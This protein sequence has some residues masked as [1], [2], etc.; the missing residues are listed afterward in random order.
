MA[1]RTGTDETTRRP[2]AGRASL[3]LMIAAAWPQ[4]GLAQQAAP[5]ETIT[6]IGN[7]PLLGY[8]ENRNFSEADTKLVYE[9]IYNA[10]ATFPCSNMPRLGT[11][12]VLSID[13]IKDLVALVMSPD[14]PV[15]K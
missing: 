7:T 8:G 3:A 14:S 12:K 10:Q 2:W 11:N 13:Q 9:K 15:N 1:G 4:T 6:V 5:Q